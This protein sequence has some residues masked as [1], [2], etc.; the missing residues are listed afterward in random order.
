MER[1]LD[2]FCLAVLMEL[3]RIGQNVGCKVIDRLVIS[4]IFHDKIILVTN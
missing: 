2:S 4:Q 3:L 1:H